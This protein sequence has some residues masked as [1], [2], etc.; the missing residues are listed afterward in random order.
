MKQTWTIGGGYGLPSIKIKK[1][2]KP[3]APMTEGE[4][5]AL[6]QQGGEVKLTSDVELS[7][8][9][10]LRNSVILDLNGN[11]II[12]TAEGQDAIWVLTGGELTIN[13]KGNI[14]GTYYSLYAGGNAKVIINGGN[15]SG[16]AAAIYAQSTA[17][18]E[19]NDGKFEAYNEDPN[20]GPHD[21]TLN[22]KDNSSAKILVKGGE[23]VGFNPANCK[24]E[25]PN[26]NFVAEGHESIEIESDIWKVIKK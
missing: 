6:L 19:I 1:V 10:Q 14:V 9:V 7:A 13:G 23:F 15:F 2:V 18:V 22:L 17:V 26:T 8:P 25:G 5:V 12:M 3:E 24:S 4:F 21:Y 20:Y 16:V 11:D